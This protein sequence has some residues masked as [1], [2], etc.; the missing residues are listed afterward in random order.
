M[1]TELLDESSQSDKETL[2]ESSETGT[3]A[4]P[5]LKTNA[6]IFT[7][8]GNLRPKSPKTKSTGVQVSPE[9]KE[10]ALQTHG[11]VIYDNASQT[12]VM[13]QLQVCFFY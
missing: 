11:K 6:C 2:K 9:K 12:T 7:I 8:C 5:A 3:D 4:T 10:A 1:L 13:Q